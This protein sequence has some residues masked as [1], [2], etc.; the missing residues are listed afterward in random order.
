MDYSVL[1]LCSESRDNLQRYKKYIKP[2]TVAKETTI[3]LEGMEKFY[4]AF[5]SVRTLDWD[6]FSSYLIADQSKRLSDDSIIKLRLSLTKAKTYVPHIAH[7]EIVKSLIEL[8]YL[9]RIV[10]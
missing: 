1:F 2:H 5:P 6:A 8:D 9:A 4:K 7:E 10:A 3:I